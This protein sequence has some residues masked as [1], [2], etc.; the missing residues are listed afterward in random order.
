VKA[1]Y[2]AVPYATAWAV[3]TWPAGLMY[4]V[5]SG[6]ILTSLAIVLVMTAFVTVV[7]AS[8]H[9]RRVRRHRAQGDSPEQRL[10]PERHRTFI[11]LYGLFATEL[12]AVLMLVLVEA[13]SGPWRWSRCRDRW[14]RL[15]TYPR[16]AGPRRAVPAKLLRG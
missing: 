14:A 6:D 10:N 5:G 9:W 11:A 16:G 12:S 1:L 13:P 2:I 3:T 4:L 8:N 7:F 15:F